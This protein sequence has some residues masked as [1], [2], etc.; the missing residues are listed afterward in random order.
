MVVNANHKFT[1]RKKDDYLY[2]SFEY[3]LTL[4]GKFLN[5]S[6]FYLMNSWKGASEETRRRI[7]NRL[8]EFVQKW[9]LA[10]AE[11]ELAKTFTPDDG[12]DPVQTLET[13]KAK[14]WLKFYHD[15]KDQVALVPPSCV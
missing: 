10:L 5:S 9:E 6:V 2:Y 4:S 3:S 11:Y 7:I 1:Y 8:S 12:P 14:T 13:T 15:H